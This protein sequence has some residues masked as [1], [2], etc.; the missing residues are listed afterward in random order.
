[1]K[2]GKGMYFINDCLLYAGD[3][4]NDEYNGKGIAYFNNGNVMYSG[5]FKNNNYHGKG[6]SFYP[7]QK[8]LFN[9]I[10]YSSTFV[11]GTF[12][13]RNDT[14]HS[15]NGNWYGQI[16]EYNSEQNLQYLDLNLQ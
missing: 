13:D 5:D 10:F 9:G 1:M 6:V 12:Y 7:N 4:L 14:E 8:I 15:Y 3:F 2:N 11:E 16:I